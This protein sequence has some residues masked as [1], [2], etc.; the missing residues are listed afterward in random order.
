MER[1]VKL[2]AESS[3]VP[4]YILYDFDSGYGAVG[5]SL[6]VGRVQGEEAAKLGVKILKRR[7]RRFPASRRRH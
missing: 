1:F 5:G 2:F 4:L 3:S 7:Q 6:A